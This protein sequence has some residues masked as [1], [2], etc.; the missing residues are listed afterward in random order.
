MR[1]RKRKNIIVIIFL[2][3]LFAIVGVLFLP[4]IPQDINYH[5]FADK[6]NMFHLPNFW[7]VVSN[8]PYFV[9][10]MM[11][12]YKLLIL[13]RLQIL[14]EAKATYVIFFIGVTLVSFGSGYYHLAPN[15]QTLVWDR[16]PMTIAFMALFS[17]VISE[18][19]SLR[20]GK[21]LLFPLLFLG[22]GSVLYWFFGELE[23]HGDL[24]AYVLVQFLPMIVMPLMFLFLKPSF[25][26][27]RG[28]WYL[29]ICYLMAK[30][31]EALDTQIYELLGFIS[32][33]SLKHII[34]A[35]GVYI[36]LITFEKRTLM[37]RHKFNSSLLNGAIT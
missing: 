22:I 36:L 17:F 27:V 2:V 29:L 6:R 18:F 28:Y 20:L 30:V 33:H 9:V 11:A 1:G 25:S 16:L 4:A 12:L 26:L 5:N 7:N 24:R 14:Q 34:S 19:L 10:G 21:N 13:N 37:D 35:I 8:V 15:N 3:T 23:N 31:F 32:G